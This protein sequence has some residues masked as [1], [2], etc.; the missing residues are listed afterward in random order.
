MLVSQRDTIIKWT[1]QRPF[2]SEYIIQVHL[3]LF[4]LKNLSLKLLVEK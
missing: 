3:N 1:A 2:E 4:T